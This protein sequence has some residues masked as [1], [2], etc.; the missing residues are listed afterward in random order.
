MLFFSERF[1]LVPVCSCRIVIPIKILTR[2]RNQRKT[3]RQMKMLLQTATALLSIVASATAATVPTS[4]VKGA[5]FDRM[6]VI[7]FENENY[8]KSAGDCRL[9]CFSL[10]FL[11]WSTKVPD[12]SVLTFCSLSQLCMARQ[13]GH[14]AYQLLW[15]HAPLAAQLHCFR[16][17]R[18]LWS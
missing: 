14:Q 13:Q 10:F 4:N 15:R 5:A 8:A 17:R 12:C 6:A 16:W 18:L 2:N 1:L 11:W 3:D 7:Y 9:T